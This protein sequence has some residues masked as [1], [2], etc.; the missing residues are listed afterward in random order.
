MIQAYSLLGT[1]QTVIDYG[2]LFF[3]IVT[4]AVQSQVFML[5]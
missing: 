2:V 5:Q 4:L 1:S 3:S